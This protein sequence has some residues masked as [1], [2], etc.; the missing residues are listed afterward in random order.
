VVFWAVQ[1]NMLPPSS[2]F[3]C[4]GSEIRF[5]YKEVR[6]RVVMKPKERG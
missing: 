2:G 5:L 6:R 3:K 4:V 1:R